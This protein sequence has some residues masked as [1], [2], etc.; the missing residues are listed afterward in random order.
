MSTWPE[1]ERR[2]FLRNRGEPVEDELEGEGPEG[3]S[4]EDVEKDALALLAQELL[5]DCDY[6]SRVD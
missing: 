5:L 3:P 6:L 4:D 2:A 1:S